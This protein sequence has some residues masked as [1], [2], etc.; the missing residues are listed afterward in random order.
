ML[1]Q[2]TFFRVSRVSKRCSG[3]FN[4]SNAWTN[5]WDKMIKEKAGVERQNSKKGYGRMSMLALQRGGNIRGCGFFCPTT[6]PVCI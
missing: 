5:M 2:I 3:I 4:A 1:R 6:V